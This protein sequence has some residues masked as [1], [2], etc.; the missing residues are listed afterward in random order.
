MTVYPGLN[1]KGT[2]EKKDCV[3][4]LKNVWIKKGY[5]IID[6]G[7]ARAGNNCPC[8]NTK[9]KPKSFKGLGF[10]NAKIKF[11]GSKMIDE[12]EHP[13]EKDD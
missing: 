10:R 3:A 2:C 12:E 8:C 5:G 11:K 7:E 6:F 4:Y 1:I 13:Y 9:M